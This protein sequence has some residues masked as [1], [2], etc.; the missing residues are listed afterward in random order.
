MREK[1]VLTCPLVLWEFP[2]VSLLGSWAYDNAE[3]TDHIVKLKV[4]EDVVYLLSEKAS[5]TRLSAESWVREFC[6]CGV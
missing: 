5:F 6:V 3:E 1:S 4:E 2:V